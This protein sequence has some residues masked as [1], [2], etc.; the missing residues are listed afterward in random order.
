MSFLP[1]TIA[2]ARP[3]PVT[4]RMLRQ[5]TAVAH[6]ARNGM[7]SEAECEWLLSVAGPLMDELQQRRAYMAGLAQGDEFANVISM[8]AVR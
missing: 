5:L 6:S 8:P 1:P 7:A 4:D 3:V 2:Q